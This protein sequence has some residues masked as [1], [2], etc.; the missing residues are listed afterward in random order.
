MNHFKW[1]AGN[2]AG[3]TG[4]W[5]G[6]QELL[7]LLY[8]RGIRNTNCKARYDVRYYLGY[9]RPYSFHS[10]STV[11]EK[12]TNETLEGDYLPGSC[13]MKYGRRALIMEAACVSETAVN[14][15]KPES[16]K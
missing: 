8:T 11:I 16:H 6:L 1:P 4:I 14:R 15:G 7:L 3:F 10:H 9:I 5:E 12:R 13:T 2:N